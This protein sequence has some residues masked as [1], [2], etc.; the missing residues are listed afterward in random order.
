MTTIVDLSFFDWPARPVALA[1]AIVPDFPLVDKS[2]N[3]SHAGKDL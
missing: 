1:G 2:F 3:L